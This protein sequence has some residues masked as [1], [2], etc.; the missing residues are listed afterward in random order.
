M[1]IGCHILRT[2]TVVSEQTQ[3]LCILSKDGKTEQKGVK[4]LRKKKK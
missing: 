4:K 2:K 3:D 1:L